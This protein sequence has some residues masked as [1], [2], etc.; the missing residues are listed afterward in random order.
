MDVEDASTQTCPNDF[1]S[2]YD[3]PTPTIANRVRRLCG[4]YVPADVLGSTDTM[5]VTFNTNSLEQF[6]GFS[7]SWRNVGM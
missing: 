7:L 5:I 1:I 4:F 3:G 2:I 6:R